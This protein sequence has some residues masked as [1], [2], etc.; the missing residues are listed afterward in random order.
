MI[1]SIFPLRFSSFP[2][3]KVPIIHWKNGAMSTMNFWT[4]SHFLYISLTLC[5]PIHTILTAHN[6]FAIFIPTFKSC[7]HFSCLA[8]AWYSYTLLLNRP[9]TVNFFPTLFVCLFVFG[10]TKSL[11]SSQHLV[12]TQIFHSL[13]APVLSALL[14]YPVPSCPCASHTFH[15]DLPPCFHH[16]LP[17]ILHLSDVRVSLH[18]KQHSR[19]MGKEKSYSKSLVLPEMQDPF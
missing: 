16:L 9:C 15:T 10:K 11:F 5:S 2:L 4:A 14:P 8:K 19:S 18:V 6:F 7:C 1:H 13:T 17:W 12:H 3:K